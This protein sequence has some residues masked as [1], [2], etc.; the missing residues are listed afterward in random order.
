MNNKKWNKLFSKVNEKINCRDIYIKL[1]LMDNVVNNLS[2]LTGKIKETGFGD[3]VPLGPFE[4]KE[5]EY[6]II[7]NNN[8][9]IKEILKGIGKIKY[10]IINDK[11]K[12]Y[13][14]K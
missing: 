1:L 10:E 11:I 2:D 12:I 5:I 13:G 3:I 6:I 8:E 9:K 7:K 14:Y 4:F